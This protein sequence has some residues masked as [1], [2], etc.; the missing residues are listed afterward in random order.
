MDKKTILALTGFILLLSVIPLGVYLVGQKQF[1]KPKA[2]GPI[3]IPT[4]TPAPETSFSIIAPASASPSGQVKVSLWARSDIDWANLFVAK[5]KF[6]KELLEVAE[7]ATNQKPGCVP[8]PACL[9]QNPVCLI[10]EPP[11]GWCPPGF[12]QNW[13]ENIF[14][15]SQGTISLVGGVPSPG[16]K[17]LD[18]QGGL[19]AE[20]VFNIKGVGVADLSF[21]GTSA[22]YRNSDNAD[23]LTVKRG[24]SIDVQTPE[25]F[26]VGLEA[27]EQHDT[28]RVP[29][30]LESGAPWV[31][32]NF[33]GT[34]WSEGSLDVNTYNQIINAYQAENIKIIGLIG[35][36]SVAG[37]YDRNHP[38]SFTQPFINTS[39]NII[40]RFGD[41]VKVYEL[42]NEPND[43]AGGSDAQ[44]PPRYFAQYLADIYQ[45]IKIIRVRD[46]II[47]NSGPLFTHDLDTG[48][49]YLQNTYS[50]GKN[51]TG[52]DDWDTV[53]TQTGTY[54]LD[55]VGYHIYVAQGTGEKSQIEN[56][57][58]N[59]LSAVESVISSL[60]PGKKLWI[61]EFGWGT[62]AGRV[63]EQVQ[64]DNLTL[65]FNI[66]KNDPN[67]RMA[68]WF[69]AMDWNA[70]EWG[71]VRGDGTK[72][73]SW[74]AFQSI[75]GIAPTPAALVLPTSTPIP[76]PTSTP[77]P[78]P[79][80][81][82][83][84]GDVNSDNKVSLI[85]LSALFSKYNSPNPGRADLNGDGV[86][87]AL[88]FSLMRNILIEE[89]V[90]NP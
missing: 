17:T 33:V 49:G 46:D 71:L 43:W 87:N 41:R 21:D 80:P 2:A 81:V 77:S 47:L 18:G 66:F 19:M 6:S 52:D 20:I 7:I 69:T 79:T 29:L 53:K 58:H 40:S 82:L 68:M 76:T 14:D 45:Q 48:A 74:G 50:A 65:A 85:D 63:T 89:N 24:A 4:P 15:N 75:N 11:E 8:R 1:F 57:L 16:Y 60:D 27:G 12:I 37:G 56:K 25:G 36:Q 51:L 23:I 44:V 64:A 73:L 10:A 31:R 9:N 38:E 84:K 54:P 70:E 32:L 90:I 78:T 55:G 86:V 59:N 22:I 62:G 67:I 34:D 26:E 39:D 30:V 42:F 3:S 35:A 88:D 28:S 83:K 72:K 61:S 13:V 5:L